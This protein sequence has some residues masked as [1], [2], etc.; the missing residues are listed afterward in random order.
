MAWSTVVLCAYLMKCGGCDLPQR[1]MLFCSITLTQRPMSARD[2]TKVGRG[3]LHHGPNQSRSY[4]KPHGKHA[5][6]KLPSRSVHSRNHRSCG[7]V[8]AVF[9][10][11]LPGKPGLLWLLSV[12]RRPVPFD[13]GRH[14]VFS[15]PSLPR[16]PVRTNLRQVL[17]PELRTWIPQ[18]RHRA[19]VVHDPMPARH[20]QWARSSHLHRLST[21]NSRHY[22]RRIQPV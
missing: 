8:P 4:D 16:R 13:G 14:R 11:D 15:M 19:D 21:R 7:D 17:V 10:R 6:A 22:G 20:V 12:R 9:A 5:C 1:I 3:H 2:C 18:P